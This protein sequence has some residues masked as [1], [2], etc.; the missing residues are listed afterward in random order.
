MLIV[1][2]KTVNLIM[3]HAEGDGVAVKSVEDIVVLQ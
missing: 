2:R 1:Y 3:L